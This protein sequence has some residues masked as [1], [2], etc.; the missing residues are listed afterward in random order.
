MII[1]MIKKIT[2]PYINIVFQNTFSTMTFFNPN[3]SLYNMIVNL[4]TMKVKLVVEK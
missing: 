4:Q 1:P 2:M 3:H